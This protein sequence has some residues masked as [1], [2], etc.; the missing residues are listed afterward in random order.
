[1]TLY[2]LW[3]NFILGSTCFELLSILSAIVPEHGNGCKTK[4]N[5]K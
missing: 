2:V 5:K 3:F 1:M 4:E